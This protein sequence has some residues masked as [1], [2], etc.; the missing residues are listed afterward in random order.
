MYPA[1]FVHNVG[2]AFGADGRRWLARLPALTAAVARDWGITLAAPYPLS[3][4]FVA[5]GRRADGTPV[6][7]KLG[8]PQAG[9]V[10]V[11][12]DALGFFAGDGAVRVLERDDARGAL[13]LERADPGDPLSSLVA[14]D[15]E[16]ATAVLIEVMRRLH[17]PAPPGLAL[18]ELA[19]RQAT[20]AAHLA[21]YPGAD[22]PFP[23]HLVQQAAGLL[24]E[25]C[26]SAE[27]RVVLHGDLH[28]DN[29][30]AAGREPWLVI[31]PHGVLGDPGYEIGA[32]LY[33]PLG[34]E[35]VLPLL[36]GRIEQFADGLAMPVDRVVAWGF[37]QAV[38]CEV[39]G[40]EG[41]DPAPGQALQVALTLQPRLA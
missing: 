30:L 21:R 11:E 35:A 37:V 14:A 16:R 12:A 23:R 27:R 38:L 29:V 8:V 41:G 39:W 4:N 25:L 20:F 10:A 26:E 18:P 33:N 19:A 2:D 1:A 9:H 13:L 36:P 32:A 31:D 7:L 15:D 17:R 34:Y 24:R 22:H 6:V 40:A 5:P 3:F 28:H